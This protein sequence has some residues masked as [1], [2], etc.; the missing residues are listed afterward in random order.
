MRSSAIAEEL[1]AR[2]E[3]VIF[4]GET[5]DLP[6][7]SE[8]IKSLGFS[9]T[10]SNSDGFISNPNSD[11]LL[12]DSYGI[13][14][15]DPFITI[16]N[17]LHVI[18]IVDEQTPDYECHLRIHPGLDPLWTGQS[19][20]Q[21]LAGP[22]YI[23]FRKSIAPHERETTNH[24]ANLRIA[25]IAGGSDYFNLVFEIANILSSFSEV[26]DVYLFSDSISAELFDS[27]FHK[28]EIGPKLDKLIGNLD[29]VFTTS[30]TS[31]LEFIAQGLP[32]GIACA[33]DNQEQYY[34]ALGDLGVAA[35]VGFRNSL[36]KWVL[37][38]EIIHYLVK[39]STFR[40]TFTKRAVGLIDFK[41]ASRIV[42]AIKTL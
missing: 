26:F 42:D 18:S 25:V 36:N 11:V 21:I 30:S 38:S 3:D 29:L 24:G 33:V 6:W 40:E 13:N 8:R 41:G 14:L 5:N 27:R 9:A 1:I 28:M 34:K 19:K 22:R 17:W 39:S 2:G 7:V 20:V 4:I 23:P 32:V 10:H 16:H 35:Q 12:L 31:S 15:R 37:D